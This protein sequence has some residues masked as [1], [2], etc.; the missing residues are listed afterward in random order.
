MSSKDKYAIFDQSE[1]PVVIIR[2]TGV[3]STDENFGDYLAEMTALYDRQEDLAIVFDAREASLPSLR[4][5]K[6][7]AQ[8][9][10]DH[11]ALLKKHCRG[12]AYV[13]VTSS[14][15]IILLMIFSFTSQ[16][17]PYKTFSNMPDAEAWVSGLLQEDA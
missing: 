5:Q 16:P 10:Q 1:F 17:V 4:H 3:S 8:W 11:K 6:M 2:F 7:Q 15:R 12:T 9:L 14:A 13:M